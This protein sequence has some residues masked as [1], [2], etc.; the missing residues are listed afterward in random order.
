MK[1]LYIGFIIDEPKYIETATDTTLLM[2]SECNMSRSI[3]PVITTIDRIYL[4]DSELT[5]DWYSSSYRTGED[6]A[7]SLSSI[8]HVPVDDLVKMIIMRKD[9]PVDVSYNTA[10]Q[11]LRFAEAKVIN[12]PDILLTINEKLLPLNSPYSAPDTYILNDMQL[13]SEIIENDIGKWVIKPLNEKGGRGVFML[14]KGYDNNESL[15]NIATKNGTQKILLQ[16]FLPEVFNGD[17][18]IFML[19]GKPLGWMNRVPA[20]N[21]FRANIHLG[22]SAQKCTLTTHDLDI[23]EWVNSTLPSEKVPLI[24]L[25]IIGNYLSEVNITSPSGIPE[26]NNITGQSLEKN[27]MNA[28]VGML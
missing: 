19:N 8:G 4:K 2:I 13:L 1:P 18:R 15:I 22:A 12:S 24:A 20:N 21:D 27:I 6:W 14:E 7:G 11:I 26:I 16:R 28:I 3:V 9:P 23:C 10:A 17:K 25:D 5:A